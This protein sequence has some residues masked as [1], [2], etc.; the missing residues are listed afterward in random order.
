MAL[1]EALALAAEIVAIC[2]RTLPPLAG[3]ILHGSLATGAFVPGR[4]DVDVLAIV[5]EEPS[6]DALAALTS[7]VEELHPGAA[8]AAD[9][10]V[11]TSRTAAEPSPAPRVEIYV[12]LDP[13]GGP[14]L[15]VETRRP[16]RDLVVELSVCRVHGRSLAGPSPAELI[17]RVPDEWVVDVGAEVLATWQSREYDP[18]MAAFM[19]FTTC[20]IWRFA[21]ERLHCSKQEAAR[22]ALDRDPSLSVVETALTSQVLG[23]NEVRA[24]MTL[25]RAATHDDPRR[26]PGFAGA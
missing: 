1:D 22:W 2:R 19:V 26:S 15:E 21:E 24:L 5:D 8:A 18:E 10:S 9:L 23:E 25:V 14:G 16:R 6:G 12:R 7:A 17:G 13:A 11:V 20:R 3:A 4:S